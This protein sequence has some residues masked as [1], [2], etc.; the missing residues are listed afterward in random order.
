MKISLITIRFFFLAAVLVLAAPAIAQTYKW[1]DK[2]GKTQYGDTPPPGVKATPLKRP[3]GQAPAPAADKADSKDEKAA[4]AK[5]PLTPAEQEAEFRK[6]QA[7]TQKAREKDDKAA[8]ELAAKREN[9]S[10]AQDQ[11]RMYEGG[12]RISRTD[13]K[14]ERYF[15]DEGQMAQETAKARQTVQEW[16]SK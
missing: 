3:A 12:Q 1:V 8:Q 2:N 11:L 14:G 5:G 6:R 13:A 16:C 4:A 10:N 9:C 15:L 7:D